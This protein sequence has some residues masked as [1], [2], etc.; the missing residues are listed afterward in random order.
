MEKVVGHVKSDAH[1]MLPCADIP[2][3]GLSVSKQ[4]S[5]HVLWRCLALSFLM[6]Y[7][8]FGICFPL[9]ALHFQLTKWPATRTHYQLIGSS[10]CRK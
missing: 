10:K 7:F 2:D 4:I 5:T 9:A 8:V 6:I 3:V 1:R